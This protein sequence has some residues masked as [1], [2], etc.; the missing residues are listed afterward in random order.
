[1]KFLGCLSTAAFGVLL[2]LPF[3]DSFQ[4]TPS[5][6]ARR[7]KTSTSFSLA[8]TSDQV[9]PGSAKLDTPWEELGFEFRQT[10]SHIKLTC[11]DGE[12]GEPE[13]VQVSLWLILGVSLRHRSVRHILNS[14]PSLCFL[15]AVGRSLFS[16]KFVI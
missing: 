13:L 11:K 5:N 4:L 6:F 7:H 9:R 16:N 15:V 12:W 2:S 8:S 1:M 10:N 14:S 3:S